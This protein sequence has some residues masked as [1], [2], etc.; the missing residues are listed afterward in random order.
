M[1]RMA[2]L[3]VRKHCDI[4]QHCRLGLLVR[5]KGLQSA[6][7][8]FA[9]GEETLGHRVVPT[10]AL[11]THT[12]PHPMLGEAW[13]RA[14]RALRA[15]T[16]GMQEEACC[17]PTLAHRQRQR[18]VHP[19]PP[20]E[21]PPSTSRPRPATTAR[22]RRRATA[23]LRPEE[24]RQELPHRPSRVHAPYTPACAGAEP[25]SQPGLPSSALW[26]CAAFGRGAPPGRGRAPGG[27]PAGRPA[28]TDA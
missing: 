20:A 9:G 21:A 27:G 4:F 24:E 23:S 12:G 19:M 28:P 15:A 14:R 5:L 18:L 16:V 25:P 17:R 2:A 26:M 10:G 13:P 8:R 22:A 3:T 7:R 11:P 1:G 6:H